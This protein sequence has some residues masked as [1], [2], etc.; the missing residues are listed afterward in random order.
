MNG[1][2]KQIP[3][4]THYRAESD[5][6]FYTDARIV[7]TGAD[8]IAFLKQQAAANPRRRCRL[9]AHPDPG[10]SLHE[11]LIVH[12]RETY[13]RPHCHIGKSESL[14]VIEGRVLAVMFDEDG[15]IFEVIDMRRPESGGA[16]YYRMPEGILHTL[17]IESEWLV[18]A[19][20]TSGPLDS[21][22]TRFADWAPD[23]RDAAEAAQFMKDLRVRCE[24]L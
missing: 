4:P 20:A 13:V 11:M 1:S 12:H 8:D 15:D 7:T 17:L 21:S 6:V 9:C 23:G 2:I 22:K 24:P 3:A 18:F 16:F 10:D 19:E 5:E 14:S